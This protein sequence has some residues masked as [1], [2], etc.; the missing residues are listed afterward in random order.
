MPRNT[1]SELRATPWKTTRCST[2]GTISK[3][4]SV[5]PSG[6]TREI[7]APGPCVVSGGI[8]PAVRIEAQSRPISVAVIAFVH[9]TAPE[10][11]YSRTNGLRSGHRSGSP[12]IGCAL[13]PATHRPASLAPTR[14]TLEP[15]VGP[16]PRYDV[17]RTEPS[18]P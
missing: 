7:S 16:A 12:V 1:R 8:D 18:Y 6:R 14:E 9:L 15:D 17:Q 5:V 10:S 13:V 11:A 3:R 2:A 4:H